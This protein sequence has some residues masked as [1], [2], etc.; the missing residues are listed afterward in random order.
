MSR[1][2]VLACGNP[3]RGDDALGPAFAAAIVRF[4]NHTS[5]ALEVQA[6]FQLSPEHALDLLGRDAVLFV[7]ASIDAPAPF[8]FAAVRPAHDPTFT[9]H[10][11]SPAAVLAAHADAFGPPPPAFALAI[12]GSSFDFGA[13]MTGEARSYLAAAL[14]LFE[15]LIADGDPRAWYDHATSC[16]EPA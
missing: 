4:T 7:D 5:H 14:A 16:R 9:S 10:A 3:A 6:D 11:M 13:P 1:I 12:R 2:A 15:R 8:R